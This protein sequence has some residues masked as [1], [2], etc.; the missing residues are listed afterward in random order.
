[1]L[2]T[3]AITLAMLAMLATRAITLAI[4]SF[5]QDGGRQDLGAM[6]HGGL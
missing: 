5:T 2:V 4:T 1:M 3:W 6:V